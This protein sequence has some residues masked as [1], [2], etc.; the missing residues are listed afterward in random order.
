MEFRQSTQLALF[1]NLG[2]TDIEGV[3]SGLGYR[4]LDNGF[5]VI[6]HLG[7]G[8]DITESN[9][10]FDTEITV[11]DVIAMLAKVLDWKQDWL[12][13]QEQFRGPLRVP[14]K[15]HT[16]HDIVRDIIQLNAYTVN[17]KPV[18]YEGNRNLATALFL[19]KG[20]TNSVCSCKHDPPV[21]AEWEVRTYT[22]PPIWFALVTDGLEKLP[23]FELEEQFTNGVRTYGII[24]LCDKCANQRANIL[25]DSKP[26]VNNDL[27]GITPELPVMSAT[28]QNLGAALYIIDCGCMKGRL[29]GAL[30]GNIQEGDLK[31]YLKTKYPTKDTKPDEIVMCQKD[32]PDLSGVISR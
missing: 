31:A 12:G 29:I 24:N 23:L 3:G 1:P 19:Y 7:S 6:I 2:K 18:K 27:A 9:A 30:P 22:E 10:S 28:K 11:Q 14:D 4:L 5:Y 8:K 21:K 15:K 25:M 17:G 26:V 13:V 16:K 32:L 20:E